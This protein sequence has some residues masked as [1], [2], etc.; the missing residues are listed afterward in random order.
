VPYPQGNFWRA[1]KE[2]MQI[3]VIGT[4]HLDDPRHELAL[5]RF[6]PEIAGA[7][8][9]LVEAGPEEEKALVDR[10]AKDPSVMMI[11]SGPT[12]LE[13]LPKETWDRLAEATAARGIPGF[14]AAKFRPWYIT[15]LLSMPPC[16][17]KDLTDPKGLDKQL[18]ESAQAANVPVRALEPFDTIFK[19]FGT[20]SEQDQ[21]EMIEQSLAMEPQIADFSVTLAD[22]YFDGENRLMWELMRHQSYQMPGYTRE[23][24]DADMA[25]L[26]Q[27]LMIDR[28]RSWIP[29]IEEAAKGGPLVVAFGA[30]HLS[31]NDGVLNLLAQNGWT[32]TQ[33]APQ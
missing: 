27:V 17:L 28:N 25:Q 26:E 12:L 16:A 5:A 23:Q 31:G 4:Y 20:M 13:L 29:V 2:D 8:A 19:I 30:L 32:I 9:L 7:T 15:V 22:A 6:A 33:L 21:V 14:M 18:I 3:T 10:M 1:E 24:V 11:T